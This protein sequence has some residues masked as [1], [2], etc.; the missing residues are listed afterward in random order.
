LCW[1]WYYF[2]GS[3]AVWFYKPFIEIE[4]WAACTGSW[5]LMNSVAIMVMR[6]QWAQPLKSLNLLHQLFKRKF[7]IELLSSIILAWIV[8]GLFIFGS[9]LIPMG[10]VL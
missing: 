9:W 5:G 8:G 10:Y 4:P 2:T 1:S 3:A 7:L 6:F